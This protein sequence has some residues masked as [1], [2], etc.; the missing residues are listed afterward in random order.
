MNRASRVSSAIEARPGHGKGTTTDAV[1]RQLIADITAGRLPPGS[2][3]GFEM[4][5]TRY[6]VGVSALREALQRLVSENMVVLEGH[7]GFKVAPFRLEDLKDIN[8]LR[9]QLAGDALKDAIAHA[10]PDWEGKVLAAAHR[11]SRVPLSEDPDGTDVDTWEDCH[12]EFHDALLSTCT[13]RWLLHFCRL[14]DTQY[15]RYR[16]IVLARYWSTPAVRK[17]INGEHQAIV[18]AALE[19]DADTAV[20]LLRA[21]YDKSAQGV[22][23]EYERR[24]AENGEGAWWTT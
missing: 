7:V 2:K 6:G 17:V 24:V 14:L 1:E 3:L 21:H 18:D 5:K 8:N 12:R 13:S 9:R 16:R 23:E 15:L 22:I 19:H 11:L 20:A 10:T 4:L